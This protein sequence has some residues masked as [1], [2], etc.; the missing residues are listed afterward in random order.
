MVWRKFHPKKN[1]EK[2]KYLQDRY[3][4][5]FFFLFYFNQN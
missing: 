2:H 1:I 5:E 4:T 3:V